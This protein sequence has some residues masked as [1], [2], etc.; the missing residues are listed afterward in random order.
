MLSYDGW[1]KSATGN[2]II[3]VQVQVIFNDNDGKSVTRVFLMSYE[4]QVQEMML[5]CPLSLLQPQWNPS[6]VRK[7]I[8]TANEY[9]Q[10]DK[11]R[12]RPELVCKRYV[13]STAGNDSRGWE[14]QM[15]YQYCFQI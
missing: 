11:I 10:M 9:K 4:K 1:G 13:Y 15:K 7:F 5:I 2:F 12:F 6:V 14:G 3:P 8:E